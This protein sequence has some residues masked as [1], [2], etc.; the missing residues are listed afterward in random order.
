MDKGSI[1]RGLPRL[2]M[3]KSLGLM[4]V[5]L[6]PIL[7]SGQTTPS[8]LADLSLEELLNIDLVSDTETADNA[9]WEFGYT[10]YKAEFGGYKNGTRDLSFDEVLF[11]PGEARSS[12]N[13]PVVP[14]YISQKV[15]LF[16][17]SYRLNERNTIT[18]SLPL[19][20]QE[21]DHISSVPG[22]DEFI[23]ESNGLGDIGVN[24]VRTFETGASDVL[25]ASAGI[26]IPTGSINVM[27]DTPRN[28]SGTD[29]RLPYTM[30]LGSGTFDLTA[31][32]NYTHIFKDFHLGAAAT[33]I[34]RTGKNDHNYRLGHGLT[35][36]VNARYVKS[37]HFQPGLKAG[38]RKIGSIS[39]QD[40]GLTIPGPFPYPAAITNPANYGG[41][42][43]SISV[44]ALICL[45]DDCELSLNTEFTQPVHQNLNGIQPKV[46]DKF[47]LGAKVRF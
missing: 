45:K 20:G 18:L 26:R 19:I 12:E 30:Q 11:S 24:L 16:S 38:Y 5:L 28:G 42:I 22:F 10:F 17:A 47:S 9:R 29:E 44:N 40:D 46:R 21:T 15:H 14:T 1:K 43:F 41:D 13:F 32:L 25:Q 34:I 39:G 2:T 23:L 27:G 36:S 33:T 31:G 3:R 37:V 35:T 6:A 4:S 7:A 8:E